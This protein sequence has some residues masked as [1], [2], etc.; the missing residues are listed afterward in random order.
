MDHSI[1]TL[2][3]L[4]SGTL[5]PD[6]FK[7]ENLTPTQFGIF[8]SRYKAVTTATE[9]AKSPYIQFGQGRI[10]KIPGLGSKYSD[11]I[12]KGS[13]IE[14]YKSTGSKVAKN[15]ITY[16][17]YDG[18][19]DTKTI[20]VGCDEEYSVTINAFSKYINGTYSGNGLTRSVTIKT[21]CC[22]DCSGDCDTLDPLW[23]AKEIAKKLNENP[24]LSKYI[25][26]TPVFK[27][28]PDPTQVQ[29][30]T[31]TYSLSVY[32]NGT[33]ADM[34]AV[35]AQYTNAVVTLESRT[36]PIS[37]YTLTQLASASAPAAF[38]LVQPVFLAVC[39]TCP[40]GYTFVDEQEAYIVTRPLAGTETL[41]TAGNKQTFADAVKAAYVVPKTF[42]GAL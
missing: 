30:D 27:C 42:N 6:N 17:G 14:W 5:A 28:T 23:T 21:P 8:N 39:T 29:V 18:V 3:V 2:F 32:D 36:A 33:P 19:D 12:S 35:Q 24:V 38:S 4:P 10:E 13:L 16:I 34:A 15:Q 25:V 7:R 9:A 1:T 11:K 40:S 20:K 22:A 41:V 31:V 37:V 26:A